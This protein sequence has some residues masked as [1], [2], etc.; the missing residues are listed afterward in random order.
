MDFEP[1]VPVNTK[2]PVAQR[3]V[4]EED[5]EDYTYNKREAAKKRHTR[6]SV[7]IVIAAVVIVLAIAF[8]VLWQTG[9]VNIDGKATTTAASDLVEVPNFVGKPYDEIIDDSYNSKNFKFEK[10]EVYDSTVEEGYVIE[11]SIDVNEKV[12]VGTTIKLVVS[13]GKQSIVFP[14]SGIVGMKYEEARNMLTKIGFTVEKSVKL[15]T[16][17]EQ[18]GTVQGASL[19]GGASYEKGTTVFLFVWG[20][21]VT[22]EQTTEETTSEDETSEDDGSLESPL[23][24]LMNLR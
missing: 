2:K 8:V 19:E 16:D 15:N 12:S 22:E 20:E 14:T 5:E 4:D 18:E 13:K 21:P 9:V 1:V 7:V 10:S 17:G 23:D 3:I 6:S 24:R 11:Q